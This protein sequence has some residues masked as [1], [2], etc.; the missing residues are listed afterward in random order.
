MPADSR[1]PQKI[2]VDSLRNALEPV[3]ANGQPGPE[4]AVL[5]DAT[6]GRF[7]EY[8]KREVLCDHVE[9]GAATCRF[10]EGPYGSGKT[11]LLRLLKDTALRRGMCVV[12]TELSASL[13]PSHWD[14]VVAFIL[15]NLQLHLDGRKIQ[16][17]PSILRELSARNAI[18]PEALRTIKLPHPGFRQ[19]MFMATKR[20]GAAL[21]EHSLLGRFLTG[22]RIG[23]AALRFDGISSVR[24]PLSERNAEQVLTTVLGGLATMGVPGTMLLLDESERMFSRTAAPSPRVQ[25]AAN[26]IRRMIDACTI[27]SLRNV[28]AVFAVLP[29]FLPTC[30]E[31]YPALGQRLSVKAERNGAVAWRWPVM[32]VEDTLEASNNRGA[33]LDAAIVRLLDLIRR[34]GRSVKGL[35]PAMS[36]SGAEIL[37]KHA[38]GGYKRPLMKNLATLALSRL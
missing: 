19:A 8:F 3:A 38:S 34:S 12:D 15:Q 35:G 30:A 17:L 1:G 29:D 6:S 2:S 24:D 25:L 23:V 5:L 10:F 11:H 16:S 28:V 32:Q 26:L 22:G 31:V 9:K 21:D 36:L 37:R 14:G 33:F 27:G 7:L 4:S 20:H 13:T 18:D